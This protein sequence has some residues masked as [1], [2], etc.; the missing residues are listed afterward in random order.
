[1]KKYLLFI[2]LTLFA[3]VSASSATDDFFARDP[4]AIYDESYTNIDVVIEI[5]GY[6]LDPQNALKISLEKQ[7]YE[8]AGNMDSVILEKANKYI[9]YSKINTAK[10]YVLYAVK[11]LG[12]YVLLYFHEPKIMDGGFELIYSK[13]LNNIIGSFSAGYKG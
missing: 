13:E 3:V 2:F 4:K 9:N 8:N 6:K 11:D 7:D 1:M 12:E 5:P 10:D